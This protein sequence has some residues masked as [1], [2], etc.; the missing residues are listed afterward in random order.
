MD[1]T[2]QTKGD[3]DVKNDVDV[4]ELERSLRRPRVL[5]SF[6]MSVLTGAATIA[7]M[8][9]LFSVLY[10]LLQKGGTGLNLSVFTE[11]PPPAMM[12]GGGF[13]NAIAGTI[14]I[15]IIGTAIS[16]P[17][18]V[19]AAVYTAEFGPET[20]LTQGV[21][22]SAKVL[23]GLPSILAGVFAFAAVVAITGNF[24]APAG[25]IALAILM[26]PTIL[27]TAEDAI[28]RVPNRMREAAIG[29][30]ATRTQVVTKVLLPTA[31]PGIL[32]GVMLAI[33]RGAGETAPLLFTSLFSDYWISRHKPVFLP[34]SIHDLM[35]PTASLAVLIYNY[36]G[37]PFDNQI[38]LAWTAA[39]ILVTMVL[40]TNIAGQMLAK[41]YNR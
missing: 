1:G 11:L 17:I 16:I 20:R 27:L 8:F 40:L 32:T 13:G 2:N 9:P 41:R 28:K 22:F 12:P 21:Q 31:I 29:M 6:L 4:H 5:F 7:A 24:S 19:L 34:H 35:K 18:G 39:L 26:L 25:G 30:G 36:S 3:L 23:T 15:V 33:A 10:M 14:L 38:A 37:S